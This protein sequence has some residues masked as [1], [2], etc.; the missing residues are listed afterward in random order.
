MLSFLGLIRFLQL[1]LS[2]SATSSASAFPHHVALPSLAVSSSAITIHSTSP[3]R[4][5]L[6]SSFKPAQ[7]SQTSHSL[8]TVT[9][10]TFQGVASRELRTVT[11][12]AP[13]SS[14]SSCSTCLRSHGHTLNELS[15]SPA[16]FESLATPAAVS[17]NHG[18]SDLSAS[19]PLPTSGS[20][21]LQNLNFQ[22]RM[23]TSQVLA[24]VFGSICL[25][26]AFLIVFAY[27]V[28]YKWRQAARVSRRRNKD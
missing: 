22:S 8:N 10:M 6:A 11:N 14:L 24:C 5:S 19:L 16:I 12:M 2:V 7:P 20:S 23:S 9:S 1:A 4:P 13:M 15:M 28:R 21:G 25:A 26:S 17:R 18:T 27:T 3:S